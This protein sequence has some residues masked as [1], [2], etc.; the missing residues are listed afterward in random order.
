MITQ[1]VAGRVYDYSHCIGRLSVAGD[2]F[3]FPVDL[4]NLKKIQAVATFRQ[5]QDNQA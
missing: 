5:A 4:T 1:H 3:L 2:G